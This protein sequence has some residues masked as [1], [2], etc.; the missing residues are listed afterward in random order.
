[1][2]LDYYSTSKFRS[3]RIG[4]GMSNYWGF[5]SRQIFSCLQ[6]RAATN[7]WVSRL[8]SYRESVSGNA[9]CE[10]RLFSMICSLCELA[11]LKI[12]WCHVELCEM[13]LLCFRDGIYFQWPYAKSCTC[14]RGIT[15]HPQWMHFWSYPRRCVCSPVKFVNGPYAKTSPLRHSKRAFSCRHFQLADASIHSR[16]LTRKQLIPA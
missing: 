16:A 11:S 1:M 14:Q 7:R 2:A 10:I 3:W 15:S 12:N 13:R 5:F 9:D 4:I 6:W 8:Q